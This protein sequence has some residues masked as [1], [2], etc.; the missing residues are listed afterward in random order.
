MGVSR[1]IKQCVPLLQTVW[2]YV[3]E[4]Y[5]KRYPEA[6]RLIL[7]ETFRSLAVQEAYY[8]QGRKS[9]AQIN[10]LREAAG[11][12]LL[13]ADEAKRIITK[14]QPGT[15]NHGAVDANG[16]PASRAFDVG[17]VDKEGKMDWSERNYQR[18]ATII[19][20]AFPAVTWG[21]DWDQDGQTSDEKFI[22]MPH[23]EV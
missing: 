17:F 14:K 9:Q 23:F 7:V 4:H 13:D 6:P 22:D 1:D 19:R 18:V 5:P 10:K 2:K 16:Q 8:A 11:L 3:S 21:A 20:E 15:S 12:Y